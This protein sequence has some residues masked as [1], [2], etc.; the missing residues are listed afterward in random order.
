MPDVSLLESPMTVNLR[1]LVKVLA[2]KNDPQRVILRLLVDRHVGMTGRRTRRR[3]Y[4][5]L[6]ICDYVL[7]AGRSIFVNPDITF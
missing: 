1:E 5:D 2:N 4:I 7:G 3:I 6:Y